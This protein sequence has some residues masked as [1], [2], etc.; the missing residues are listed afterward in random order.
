[1]TTLFFAPAYTFLLQLLGSSGPGAWALG[2]LSLLLAVPAVAAL[3][4]ILAKAGQPGWAALVPIYDVLVLLR[5]I[6][7]PWWWLLLLFIPVANVVPFLFICLDLA[8]AFGKGRLFG[9]GILVL[10]PAFQLVL[11]FGDARYVG[12]RA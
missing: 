9:V 7:R 2:L 10:A 11:A 6:G 3:A 8:R 12:A 5:V 4:E 1:M